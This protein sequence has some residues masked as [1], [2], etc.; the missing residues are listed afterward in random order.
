[1]DEHAAIRELLTLAAAGA[2]D[3]ADERRVEDH[4]RGCLDCRA[5]LAGW[6]RLTGA[7]E[8]LPTPQAPL[9]LVERTRSRMERHALLRLERSQNRNLLIW[10]TVFAWA[11]TLI[12]WPVLQL[13]G[14]RLGGFVDLSWTP[15]GLTQAWL[16][17]SVLAWMSTAIVAVLLGKRHQQERRTL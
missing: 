4:L 14:G 15:A 10:L 6:Q 9:A 11:S 16:G 3:D 5:E 7:L 17:Y 2:L 1:M 8:A 13:F 12:T